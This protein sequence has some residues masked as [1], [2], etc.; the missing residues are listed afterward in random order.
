MRTLV[1]MRGIAGCGKSTFIKEKGLENYTLS[2]DKIRMLYASPSL[3]INGELGINQ[4]NDGK[5]WKTLYKILE[6]RMKKGEFTVIDATHSTTKSINKYR[7]LAKEYKY[8]V[9]VLDMTDIGIDEIKARNKQRAEYKHV[10][11]DVI[12][13]M[14]RNLEGGI[15]SWVTVTTPMSFDDDM[16]IKPLDY[17]SYKKTNHIGDIHGSYTVLREYI[18]EIKEDEFYIFTGDFVDRGIENAEVVEFL[19]EIKDRK[20]VLLIEGNHEIHLNNWA[21]D[22][23]ANSREFVRNTSKEL[24]EKGISKK[25]VRKLYRKTS[26]LCYYTYNEKTILV[27]HGGLPFIPEKLHLV[28]SNDLIKGVGT[29]EDNVDSVFSFNCKENEYQV[30]GH[31]NIERLPIRN[32]NSFNLEG[33]VE[34]GGALRVVELSGE[35][36]KEIEIKNTVYNK[37]CDYKAK[38]VSIDI[39]DINFLELLRANKDIRERKQLDNI[40]SFNF[41]NKVFFDASWNDINTKARGLFINTKT[42]KI[43]NRGFD[44]FFN[45]D[46]RPSLSLEGIQNLKFPLTIYHKYNGFLGLLGYNEETNKLVYSSKSSTGGEYAKVFEQMFKNTVSRDKRDK[47][48]EYLREEN[49]SMIFEVIDPVFD[50]HIIEY[51]EPG[52]VLLDIVD[53]SPIFNKKSYNE[54]VRVGELLDIDYKQIE[55][56]IPD[57]DSFLDWYNYVSKDFYNEIEGWVIEDM[58]GF[59]FKVKA[60]YYSFWK[61]M[62]S[63]K[64]RVAKGRPIKLGHFAKK[65]KGFYIWL[66][67]QDIEL[68][69]KDII[70]L[71]KLYEQDI[72]EE[73]DRE[74]D[75]FVEH[76]E[77]V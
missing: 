70:S 43:V 41:T 18:K 73:E 27:T 74:F 11:E 66:L 31:R 15:P 6:E 4:Y 52:V 1:L 68:L 45:I 59:M 50:P 58:E 35:G 33:K 20:N 67:K 46:E 47:I 3:N 69:A 39:K 56:S 64:D 19:I 44:K 49:T 60:P 23:Q 16:Q 32:G 72:E 54:L 40:S 25:E 13:K 7:K 37:D 51:D 17:S 22:R 57:Y 30:H 75:Y 10:P 55:G 38:E 12:N 77:H 2:A 28:A 53:R 76:I 8:R 48:K 21:N 24:D 26:Q 14:E 29:Y 5:V 61:K 62:R 63:M 42:G 36:F 9:W 34:L 65:T 71:R